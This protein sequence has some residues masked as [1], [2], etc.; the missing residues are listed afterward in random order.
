MKWAAT[1]LRQRFLEFLVA[2]A[3][4]HVVA[5]VI[6]YADDIPHASVGMQRTFAMIWMGLTV[7]VV[8]VGMQ[9]ITRER[10]RA[11]SARGTGLG[12]R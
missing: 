12:P 3:L 9:R 6:Y 8:L 10:R 2:V 5:I 7:A 1:P 4:V 11:R